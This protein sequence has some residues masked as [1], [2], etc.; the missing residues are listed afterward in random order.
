MRHLQLR[1]LVIQRG[2]SIIVAYLLDEVPEFLELAELRRQGWENPAGNRHFHKQR[3][4]ADKTGKQASKYHYRLMQKIGEEIHNT[5]M[6]LATRTFPGTILDMCVAPGGFLATD[7]R[8]NPG[9]EP[10]RFLDITMLAADMGVITLPEDHQDIGKFLPHQFNETQLFELVICDGQ[11]LRTDT[12]EP[13]REP[14]E[15]TRLKTV[16]LALGLDH[17]KPGGTM[18][19][20][21]HKLES[22][23]TACYIRKF[24]DSHATR[25]SFYM[26][27]SNVQSQHRNARL[28][29]KKWKEVWRA[30]IFGSEEEFMEAFFDAGTSA[31]KLLEEFG[32]ELVSNG[33]EIWPV[34]AQALA[35]ASF[36]KGQGT[37]AFTG[38]LTLARR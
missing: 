34:Q 26:V 35:R 29:V 2:T 38:E 19:V 21:F 27:A 15:P 32:S 31:E 5:T 1:F 11:V 13:Y 4:A 18:I 9:A 23:D 17:M 36:I 33:R 6:G 24:S 7:K 10:V 14:R 22:W 3:R 28:A 30:A 16:Q 37:S 8:F 12:Q 25:S 20:L